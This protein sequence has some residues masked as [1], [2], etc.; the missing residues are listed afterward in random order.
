M[1][2]YDVADQR[3]TRREGLMLRE[4][5]VLRLV[6]LDRLIALAYEDDPEGG[7]LW[8][9]HC[10]RTCISHLRRKLR[11]GWKISL[12]TQRGYE[13]WKET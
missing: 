6:H 5:I 3:L 12:H 10:V 9:G 13:L 4:L 8:A 7:A 1:L 11:P 2:L